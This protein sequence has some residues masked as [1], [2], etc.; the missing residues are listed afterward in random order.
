MTGTPNTSVLSDDAGEISAIASAIAQAD[1]AWAAGDRAGAVSTLTALAARAPKAPAVWTRL[2]GYALESGRP[3]AALGYLQSAVAHAPGDA[4]AWTNLGIAL[5]RLARTDD[6]IAAYRHALGLAPDAV[7]TRVNLGNALERNGDVD[8]AVAELEAA[9][10]LAPNSVEV[11]NNLGNLYKD[12]GRFEEAFAA[13]DRA[14]R[15]RPDSRVAFSNLLALTKLSTRHTPAEIHALHRDFAARFEWTSQ[16]RYVPGTHSPDPE[17]RLRIGYLSPDCHTALPPFIEPVLLRHDRARYDVYAYFNNPQSA[18]TLARMGPITSRVMMKSADDTEVAQWIRD[19]GIDILIDIAGHTGHNRLGVLASKPAPVQVT[20]LD[21]LNTTGLESVDYRLTDAVSDPPGATE[22]LHSETLIRLAPAQWCWSP[23]NAPSPPGPLPALSSGDALTLGSFNNGSKL[24]DK[25]LALWAALLAAVPSARLVVVGIASERARTRIE[26][27]L[28][29]VQDGRVEVLGRLALDAFRQVVARTDIALDPLPFSGAT[30]T[31]EALWQ[32]LPVVTLPGATSASRSSASILTALNL[33]GWIA[34]DERDYVAIVLRASRSLD[35]LA[36]L[37]LDLRRRLQQS[38]LCDPARFAAGLEDALR[39]AWRTWCGRKAGVPPPVAA[40]AAAPRVSEI[41]ARRRVELDARLARLDAALRAG[42]GNIA[43]SDACSLVDD[44]PGWIAAQRAYVQALLAWARTQP[45]LVERTF[46]PPMLASRPKVS[47]LICSIDPARFR[48][49]TSNY[50]ARFDG[51]DLDI[52]GMHDARSLA[53]GYNR[54]AAQAAGDILIF[55]HDDVE[56][57]NADFAPRLVAHLERCDGVGIAGTSRVTGPEWG[58]AGA[59]AI[60]GHVLHR[61]PAGQS[62]VLLMAA[63]FQHVVA[64][65]IRLLDGA[66]IAVRRHVWE[67]TRFDSERYDGFHLYDVDFTWRASAA[68]ARLAVPSDLL[69]FHA[70]QGRYDEAWRR[71]A[72]RFT[73]AAGLDPLA[74]PRPG[75]LQVRLETREQV[76]LLRA[77][78]VH[79]RYGADIGAHP[80]AAAA[81]EDR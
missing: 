60:H 13:Y 77:A 34:G 14:R 7:G 61:P 72:R 30:T 15:A 22:P 35:A 47:V 55:S 20:W 8:E 45:G 40:T 31:F 6:A 26:T 4:S 44:E 73:E 37:R 5:A 74:P 28:G 21:Y 68:G 23:P 75:G 52:V 38:A 50:R 56:L 81:T 29:G 10:K 2:G 16:R 36:A 62:G 17:R 46:P 79:F 66:F 53:E 25:T 27:A 43:V 32:G 70:S 11:L 64:P 42:H 18:A 65:D 78:M 59:R 39:F 49:V 51:Y 69:L 3:D 71:Y 24:T 9:S 41:A 76:D 57:V 48:T 54:A 19:D 80:H 1:A 33:G 58:H 67:S 63:G 12:Q